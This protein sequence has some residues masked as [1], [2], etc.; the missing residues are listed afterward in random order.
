ME[1]DQSQLLFLIADYLTRSTPCSNAAA[2]LQ[3]ELVEH[4]LL[5]STAEPLVVNGA[6]RP[7]TYDDVRRRFPDVRPDLLRELAQRARPRSARLVCGEP[8]QRR[9]ATSGFVAVRLA[10]GA[11]AVRGAATA[12]PALAADF[13][14]VSPSLPCSGSCSSSRAPSDSAIAPHGLLLACWARA[15]ARASLRIAPRD[16]AAAAAS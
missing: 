6:L 14:F 15:R 13:S 12:L 5:G 8:F 1:G 11:A 2:A 16:G 10:H 7:A 3:A 4:R 9:S